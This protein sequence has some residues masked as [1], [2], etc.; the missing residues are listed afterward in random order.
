MLALSS[1]LL[2]H[3]R[4][5][6]RGREVRFALY[7][8]PLCRET[9]AEA[10]AEVAAMVAAIDEGRIARRRE[11]VGGARGMWAE[12]DDPLTKLD[13]NEGYASRL[14]GSPET[15]YR[16]MMAFHDLGIDMFHLALGDERFEAEVLP[17]LARG[18]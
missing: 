7:A 3:Q 8:I 14:I 6:A 2:V 1:S 16:R 17:R 15:I 10:E 11:R 12:S 5:P 4:S 9:D 13:S 18:G